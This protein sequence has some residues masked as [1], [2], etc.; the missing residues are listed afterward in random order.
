[1][2]HASLVYLNNFSDSLKLGN[3]HKRQ[4]NVN[5]SLFWIF[6]QTNLV[7]G[8]LFHWLPRGITVR[9]EYFNIGYWNIDYKYISDAWQ[10]RS[11]R[12]TN[13]ILSLKPKTQHNMIFSFVGLKCVVDGVFFSQDKQINLPIN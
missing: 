1:M 7:I 12:C 3:T 11:L 10:I 5:L 6:L 8:N 4:K 13:P 9:I 2:V